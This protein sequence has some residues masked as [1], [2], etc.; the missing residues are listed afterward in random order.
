MYQTYTVL[1]FHEREE[2]LWVTGILD[3]RKRARLKVPAVLVVFER[4]PMAVPSGQ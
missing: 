2:E 4:C 3:F 1:A